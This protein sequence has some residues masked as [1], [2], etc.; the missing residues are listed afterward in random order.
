MVTRNEKQLVHSEVLKLLRYNKDTGEVFWNERKRG[1]PVD[2]P[3][4]TQDRYGYRWIKIYG[5]TYSLSRL[6]WF[7]YYGKFPKENLDYKNGNPKDLR[8]TNL[9]EIPYLL[10]KERQR[11]RRIST[12]GAKGVYKNKDGVWKVR[13]MKDGKAHMRGPFLDPADAYATHKELSQELFGDLYKPVAKRIT[14]EFSKEEMQQA[15]SEFL[16]KD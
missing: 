5:N 15:L 7:M 16:N 3:A 8:I 9:K 4:G 13:I 12:E 6:V 2:K 14:R 11:A 1:R 10:H